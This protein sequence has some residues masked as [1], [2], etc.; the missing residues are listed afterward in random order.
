MPFH[1]STLLGL[2]LS[3]PGALKYFGSEGGSI[4][5]VGSA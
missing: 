1:T 2:N 5:N 4:I 3:S